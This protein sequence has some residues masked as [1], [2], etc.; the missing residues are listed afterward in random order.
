MDTQEP[1]SRYASSDAIRSVAKIFRWTNEEW[2]QDWPLEISEEVD[3]QKCLEG[4]DDLKEDE[5]FVLMEAMLYALDETV[6]NK[7]FDQFSTEISEILKRDLELHEYTVYYWTMYGS[8]EIIGDFNVTPM[9]RQ[10]W[11]EMKQLPTT[12]PKAN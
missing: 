1:K 10:V 7:K 3:I 6:D 12:K 11:K 2:M 8:P 4:Y 9:C 5:K